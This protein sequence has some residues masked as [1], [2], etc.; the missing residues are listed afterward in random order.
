[1]QN[2]KEV[3]HITVKVKKFGPN[4]SPRLIV[5]RRDADPLPHFHVLIYV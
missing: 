3:S 2:P 4:H 5:I 1:M